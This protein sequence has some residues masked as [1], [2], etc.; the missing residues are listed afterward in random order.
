MPKAKMIEIMIKRNKNIQIT[1]ERRKKGKYQTSKIELEESGKTYISSLVFYK[2]LKFYTQKICV[3]ER[4]LYHKNIY[5]V[6]AYYTYTVYCRFFQLRKVQI[7]NSSKN[8][9]YWDMK[10]SRK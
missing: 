3:Y 7:D 1:H 5:N 4:Y 9:S 8:N 10:H 6:C 2:I